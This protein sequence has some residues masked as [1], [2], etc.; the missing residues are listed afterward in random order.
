[1]YK[2]DKG[3][4]E[5]ATGIVKPRRLSL[6]HL[7][8]LLEHALPLGV[9]EFTGSYFQLKRQKIGWLVTRTTNALDPLQW[10]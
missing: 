1:M 10:I 8:Q 6:H 9:R 5:L 7:R 2:R 4:R 3:F